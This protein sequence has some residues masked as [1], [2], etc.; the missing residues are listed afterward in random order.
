VLNLP[1]AVWQELSLAEQQTVMSDWINAA[2]QKGSQ[3]VFTNNPA[4]APAGSGLAYEY[5]Y[6]T[7]TVGLQIV[8][9]GTSWIVIP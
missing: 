9:S 6:I 4:M 2:L 8:Q 7:N 1:T 3:I 5:G